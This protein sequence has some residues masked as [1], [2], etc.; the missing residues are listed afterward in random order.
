MRNQL[1]AFLLLFAG[2]VC[3]L[4]VLFLLSAILNGGSSTEETTLPVILFSEMKLIS[5]CHVDFLLMV[6]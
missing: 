5:D 2:F 4:H 1:F 6:F 3:G